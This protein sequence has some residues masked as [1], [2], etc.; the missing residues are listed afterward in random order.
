MEEESVCKIY[1]LLLFLF[2]QQA[3]SGIP[4]S[5]LYRSETRERKGVGDKIGIITCVCVCVRTKEC[6]M[7][8]YTSKTK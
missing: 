2:C 8:N 5:F 1:I 6:W 3:T 4:A 7:I